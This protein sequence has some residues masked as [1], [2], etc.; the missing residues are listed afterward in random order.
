MAI[1]ESAKA[2]IFTDVF[3]SIQGKKKLWKAKW[4]S[5]DLMLIKITV[6]AGMLFT[7]SLHPWV[8]LLIKLSEDTLNIFKRGNKN[9]VRVLENRYPFVYT[10]K[11]SMV[12]HQSCCS[13]HPWSLMGFDL[14]HN[15]PNS[16]SILFSTCLVSPLQLYC[17]K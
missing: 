17:F 6:S 13:S 12:I 1:F 8:T 10:W 11:L 9:T 2:Y 4:R 7:F 14:H 15:L 5:K 3:I 16:A